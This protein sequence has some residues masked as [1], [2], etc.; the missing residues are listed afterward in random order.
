MRSS[1]AEGVSCGQHSLHWRNSHCDTEGTG[2]AVGRIRWC[3]T[4]FTYEELRIT[5]HYIYTFFVG[6]DCST[7]LQTV[8]YNFLIVPE[9]LGVCVVRGLT[10]DETSEVSQLCES[11][12]GLWE[13]CVR[14]AW[15]QPG[16]KWA[17]GQWQVYL[18]GSVGQ[19]VAMRTRA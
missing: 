19:P 2:R 3:T 18:F 9:A 8:A 13:H 4:V 11:L 12:D 15:W 16:D 7:E 5:K 1:F 10:R 14:G 6:L 17:Q